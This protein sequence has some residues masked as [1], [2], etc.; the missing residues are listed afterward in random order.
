MT[1]STSPFNGTWRPHVEVCHHDR[2]H[3]S[4]AERN[5]KGAEVVNLA[6]A[7]VDNPEIWSGRAACWGTEMIKWVA[8][9]NLKNTDG[10][11]LTIPGPWISIRVN[12]HLT[13][14]AL[15]RAPGKSD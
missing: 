9:G 4:R 1:L 14:Q 13:Q 11:S 10:K 6:A 5:S 12:Q 3:Y 7:L 15:T 8:D 2:W